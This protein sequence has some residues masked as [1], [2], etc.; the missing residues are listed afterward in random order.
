MLAKL[1]IVLAGLMGASGVA[2]S[3]AS[4]HA[5]GGASLASAANIL[6]FHA[7]AV[8]ALVA[9]RASGALQGDL[10]VWAGLGLALGSSLF[11]GDIALRVFA[12]VRLFPMAAPSG[13]VVLILSWLGVAVAGLLGAGRP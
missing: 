8:L 5:A 7:A 6:L 1:S 2:L 4:A 12:G 13:G 10:A 9:A 11:A 3:A